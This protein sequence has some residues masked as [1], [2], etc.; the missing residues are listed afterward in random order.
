MRSVKKFEVW[1]LESLV[2]ED[3]WKV[4]ERWMEDE[5]SWRQRRRN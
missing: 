3:G 1:L 4:D 5:G 2:M